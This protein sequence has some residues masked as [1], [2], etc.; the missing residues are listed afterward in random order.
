M[1]QISPIYKFDR[2]NSYG[3]IRVLCKYYPNAYFRCNS[4]LNGDMSLEFFEKLPLLENYE[5][6]IDRE[7]SM[8][9]TINSLC[10]PSFGVRVYDDNIENKK[11]IT[12]INKIL[13]QRISYR[14]NQISVS[15][16]LNNIM[17][18]NKCASNMN[19]DNITHSYKSSNWMVLILNNEYPMILTK[20]FIGDYNLP[21]LDLNQGYIG[22]DEISNELNQHFKQWKLKFDNNPNENW[23]VP[24]INV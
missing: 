6:N 21:L 1:M 14:C 12:Q 22:N 19:W 16:R 23:N 24:I 11:N 4:S 18:F 2:K 15:Q 13:E 10:A 5:I 8:M 20:K 7:H 17:D 9:A 3:W